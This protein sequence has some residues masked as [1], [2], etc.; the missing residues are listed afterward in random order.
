MKL[1]IT[2]SAVCM[3]M[4]VHSQVSIGVRGGIVGARIHYAT[5]NPDFDKMGNDEVL[6]V[7][8]FGGAIPIEFKFGKHFALQTEIGLS[9]KGWRYDYDFDQPT[10]DSKFQVWL[11]YAEFSLLPKLII[12]SGKLK[13]HALGGLT[14][15]KAVKGVYEWQFAD[16][17]LAQLASKEEVDRGDDKGQIHPLAL[18]L[19]GGV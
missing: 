3:N 15:G 14:A 7:Y 19:V 9:Q 1:L 8:G 4:L 16:P 11:M 13:G 18:T 6:S 12:G 2:L 5:N 10:A 17:S